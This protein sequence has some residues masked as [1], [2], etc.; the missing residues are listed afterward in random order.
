[1]RKALATTAAALLLAGCSSDQ[2]AVE[3]AALTFRAPAAWEHKDLVSVDESICIGVLNREKCVTVLSTW[4]V[5]GPVDADD[6]TAAFDR[7]GWT[8]DEIDHCRPK[9]NVT[10][11]PYCTA[12]ADAD[13]RTVH[14][15]AVRAAGGGTE[16]VVRVRGR[17][18]SR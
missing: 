18:A 14:L 5:D 9:D 15:T 6:V 7:S 8:L 3:E 4:A 2:Q 10:G 16:V 11:L 13:G 17:G 1:M 12:W